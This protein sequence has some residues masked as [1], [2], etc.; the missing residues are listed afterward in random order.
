METVTKNDLPQERIRSNLPGLSPRSY[1]KIFV[2]NFSASGITTRGASMFS[3]RIKMSAK[4][5]GLC[6]WLVFA[7]CD[8]FFLDPLGSLKLG[9]IFK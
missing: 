7:S 9:V 5:S 8:W 6:T 2:P 4:L 1:F 3:W